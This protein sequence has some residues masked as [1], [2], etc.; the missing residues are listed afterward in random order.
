LLKKFVANVNV[1]CVKNVNLKKHC[2]RFVKKIN[3]IMKIKLKKQLIKCMYSKK[4]NK[5]EKVHKMVN[6]IK[7]VIQTIKQN[8][9]VKMQRKKMIQLT[10]LIRHNTIIKKLI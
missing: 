8:R 9:L 10:K 2:N 4:N 7:L 1:K 3:K 6:K 5:I